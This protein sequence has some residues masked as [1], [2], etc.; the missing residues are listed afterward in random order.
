MDIAN[1]FSSYQLIWLMPILAVVV[2]LLNFARL[3]VGLIR[4]IAGL[5]PFAILI[6]A[7]NR[8]GSDLFGALQF[9]AWL[10]LLFGAA[11]VFIP[12]AYKPATSA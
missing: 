10:A 7:V 12:S 1:H 8:L 9:G 6:Y 3:N 2:C 11:L 4:R 5:C